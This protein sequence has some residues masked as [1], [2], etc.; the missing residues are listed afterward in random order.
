[1]VGRWCAAPEG[2]GPTSAP[3]A[4]TFIPRPGF[5][6]PTLAYVL[7][8]LV[9][10]SRRVVDHHFVRRLGAR[11]RKAGASEPRTDRHSLLSRPARNPRPPA[12][13]AVV[14]RAVLD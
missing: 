3:G 1:M 7:D 12:A 14:A 8:S 4:F 5:A 13:L 6:T 10:V 2:A 9:R 11:T